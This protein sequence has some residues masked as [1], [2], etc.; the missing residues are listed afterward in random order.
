MHSGLYF[1]VQ[2]IAHIRVLAYHIG[3]PFSPVGMDEPGGVPLLRELI[4]KPT[5]RL[6]YVNKVLLGDLNVWVALTDDGH[7]QILLISPSIA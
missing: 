4:H 1:A 2:P 7:P 6:L 3:S 5:N